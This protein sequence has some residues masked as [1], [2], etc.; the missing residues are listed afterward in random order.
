MMMNSRPYVCL[1]VSQLAACLGLDKFRSV[2]QALEAVWKRV[3]PWSVKQAYSRCG[4]VSQ[5]DSVKAAIERDTDIVSAVNSFVDS[6]GTSDSDKTQQ[7]ANTLANEYGSKYGTNTNSVQQEIR[8]K[9]YTTYGTAFESRVFNAVNERAVFPVPIVKD[10]R[11]YSIPMGTVE[12]VVWHVGGR[13]DAALADGTAIVEIKNRI[14]RLYRHIRH[15]DMM[16]VQAYLQLLNVRRGF[17]VECLSRNNEMEL[18]VMHTERDDHMW[19]TFVIPRLTAFV[20]VLMDVVK[21]VR[22][23]DL[24]IGSE[25]RTTIVTTWLDQHVQ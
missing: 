9:I 13:I 20:R 4:R 8:S 23:Q 10:D 11:F 6:I 24:L 1:Y 25:Q 22:K 14:Y 21:D 7:T 2:D 3:D 17:L 16:Q 15:H 19:N 18:C 12:G 5:A